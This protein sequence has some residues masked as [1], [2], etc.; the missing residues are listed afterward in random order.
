MVPESAPPGRRRSSQKYYVF[1]DEQITGPYSTSELLRLRDERKVKYDTPCCIA[2]SQEWKSVEVFLTHK[3]G[4]RKF[5]RNKATTL[6]SFSRKSLPSIVFYLFGATSASVGGWMFLSDKSVFIGLLMFFAG[7]V[8][9]VVGF[10][11]FPNTR[12]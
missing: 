8:L 4:N 11:L 5:R 10:F 9:A 2:G 6:R 3:V 7:F 12:D 1:L